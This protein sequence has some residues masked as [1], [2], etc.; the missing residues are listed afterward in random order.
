MV[1]ADHLARPSGHG[2]SLPLFPQKT[3]PAP[4]AAVLKISA[5]ASRLPTFQIDILKMPIWFSKT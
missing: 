3:T 4:E 1:P 5:F 2:K